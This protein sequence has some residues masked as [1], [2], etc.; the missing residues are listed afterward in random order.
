[1][2]G[3]WAVTDI[4]LQ[5]VRW[6]GTRWC[7]PSTS[8]PACWPRH[9]SSNVAKTRF[10][11]PETILCR[12]RHIWAQLCV[13]IHWGCHERTPAPK[14]K[15]VM[16]CSWAKKRGLKIYTFIYVRFFFLGI[17]RDEVY[18]CCNTSEAS[19][20]VAVLWRRTDFGR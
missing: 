13:N 1:M 19:Q 18:L 9:D 14:K 5:N 3:C 16:K 8:D 15:S 17:S 4:S 12:M 11:S 6:P 2:A 10:G 7:W 20:D